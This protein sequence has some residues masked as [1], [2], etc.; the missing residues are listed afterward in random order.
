MSSL[1]LHRSPPFLAVTQSIPL[2]IAHV[3]RCPSCGDPR[4]YHWPPGL[5]STLVPLHNGMIWQPDGGVGAVRASDD[6]RNCARRLATD[7]GRRVLAPVP[8]EIRL[9][10]D[11]LSLYGSV[12]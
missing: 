7:A 5:D 10:R 6:R 2:W 1:P 4:R 9:I 3:A 8:F 11:C 12:R